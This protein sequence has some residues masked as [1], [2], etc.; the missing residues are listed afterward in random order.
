MDTGKDEAV[1]ADRP[2]PPQFVFG[3][4]LDGVVVDFYGAMRGIAAEWLGVPIEELTEEVTWGLPQWNLDRMGGYIRLHRFAVIQRRLF[5]E[6]PPIPGAPA[7]LRRLVKNEDIRIRIIT[8]RLYVPHFHREAASQTIDWLDHHGIP[9]WD[10]CLLPDKAAVGA[11][12]Y[13]DDAPDNVNAL[14]GKGHTTIVFS[15]STNRDLPGP[16]AD[17]WEEVEQLVLEELRA[18]R[19]GPESKMPLAG[20]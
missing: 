4:D 9:Y 16:R 6:A 7:V 1:S 18:W 17:N 14:R 8:N 2:S 19:E 5:A 10:L 20:R 12:L 15:N 11:D 3:V 13:I